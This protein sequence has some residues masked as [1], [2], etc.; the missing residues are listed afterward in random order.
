MEKFQA[1]VS[2]TL[3]LQE[4]IQDR[5]RPAELLRKAIQSVQYIDCDAEQFLEDEV[6]RLLTELSAAVKRCQIDARTKRGE[7]AEG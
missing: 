2:D 6:M 7:E 3:R 4:D 1:N 5:N